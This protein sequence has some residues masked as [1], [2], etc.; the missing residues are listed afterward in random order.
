M[1]HEMD[2]YGIL[3]SPLLVC[4]VAAWLTAQVVTRIFDRYALYR[5][6][7]SRQLFDLATLVSLT[8]LFAFIFFGL[9]NRL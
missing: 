5:F 1:M 3:I 2:L 8:G 7:A 6:V 4:F 9:E